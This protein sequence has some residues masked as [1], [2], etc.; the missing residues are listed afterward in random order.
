MPDVRLSHWLSIACECV[1]GVSLRFVARR[2]VAS[3]CVALTGLVVLAGCQSNAPMTVAKPALP[4]PVAMHEF[5][6]DNNGDD[7][8]GAVQMIRANEE[9]TLSD[10]ARRFNVGYEEIV[11]ANPGVDPWLPKAGTEIVVPTQFVLPNAPRK[12]VVI[13]LAAMRLYYFPKAKAGTPQ[14]MI[15]HPIG[16]GRVGWRTPEGR[17]QIISK[18]EAPA[19]VPTPSIR[20]EHAA[21]GDPLPARVP[22][23]PDNPMGSHVLRLGWPEY[24]IHGTDKPPSI[25]LR[26]SHGCLRLYPEDIASLYDEVPVGTMVTVVNQPQLLGWRGDTLYLQTYAALEDDKRNHKKA[27]AQLLAAERK[28]AR[29][30]LGARPKAVVNAALLSEVAENPQALAVPVSRADLTLPAYRSQAMH[31]D[32]RLPLHA[33][34]DGDTSRQLTAAEVLHG[35]E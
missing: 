25:G 8:V 27:L 10:I 21:N 28:S 20:K 29:A 22:P 12:G 31:V 4:V 15:T 7:V 3:R 11:S 24:A 18:Q 23:G 34:W 1:Q 5:T 32:N 17:T 14:K 26:G 6:L 16:I 2:V 13:N 19:W 30:K 35:A 9:D 33:T